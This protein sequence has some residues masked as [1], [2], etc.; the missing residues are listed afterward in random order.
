MEVVM[1]KERISAALVIGTCRMDKGFAA[2]DVFLY[3]A[4]LLEGRTYKAWIRI[5]DSKRI[6]ITMLEK[7]LCDYEEEEKKALDYAVV[8]LT[9]SLLK[10]W[11]MTDVDEDEDEKNDVNDYKR[12]Q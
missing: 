5:V 12:L 3:E 10:M 7:E 11:R 2:Y 8:K 4:L 1:T 6:R 9:A